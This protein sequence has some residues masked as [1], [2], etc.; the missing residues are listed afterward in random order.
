[1]LLFTIS[2]S[3][4]QPVPLTPEHV[5]TATEVAP[6]PGPA[7]ALTPTTRSAT[8]VP[9]VSTPTQALIPLTLTHPVWI[10]R[11]KIVSA[12]FLPGV[13]QIAIGWGNG[14]SLNTVENG[15]ELWF[16]ETPA[17][18]IAFDVQAQGRAFAVALSDGSVMT[19]DTTSG[20]PTR[21]QG[22]KQSAMWGDIAWSPDGRTLAFQYLDTTNRSSPVYLLEAASG[23]IGEVPN[24][25]TG[26]GVI[27]SLV[28]SPD[29]SAILIPSLGA[30]LDT[31]FPRFV[32]IQ[33]GQERMYLAQSGQV[34][35]SA[36]LFL[37]DG[38][39]L[40]SEG[41]SGTVELLRFS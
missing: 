23:H 24:S 33:S 26:D 11:G 22:G 10:G 19:F 2:C 7:L 21:F 17:N 27:P 29:G 25:Q 15:Q 8:R 36:P 30:P 6:Q 14:V 28:W 16:H 35:S 40:A 5:Q 37:A 3:P 13:Q 31:P 1:M 12:V 38:K 34:V 32:D 18:V 4:A 41:P 20:K 39:I 9:L